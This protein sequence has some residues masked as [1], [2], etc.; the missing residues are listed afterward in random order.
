MSLELPED[1]KKLELEIENRLKLHYLAQK[2]DELNEHL[3]DHMKS[4][5]SER[6]AIDRKLLMIGIVV[7]VDALFPGGGAALIKFLI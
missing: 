6:K 3:K 7:L 1:M 5:E 4:E 2:V